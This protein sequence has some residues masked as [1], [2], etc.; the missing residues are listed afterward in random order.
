MTHNIR[1]LGPILILLYFSSFVVKANEPIIPQKTILKSQIKTQLKQNQLA[2]KTN[3]T[4]RS[5]QFSGETYQ[6][7]TDLKTG[8]KAQ[9]LRT[10]KMG[11]LSGQIVIT[12]QPEVD[13]DDFIRSSRI[14]IKSSAPQIQTVFIISQNSKNPILEVQEFKKDPRVKT[15]ELEVIEHK[16][17]IK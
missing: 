4:Q 14:K 13:I 6:L 16:L 7:Q 17:K 15:V 12:L 5:F 9:N 1:A 2:I 3:R 8:L 11:E 10:G